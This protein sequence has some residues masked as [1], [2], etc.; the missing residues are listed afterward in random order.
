MVLRRITLLGATAL[1]V[2]V[3]VAHYSNAAEVASAQEMPS[4]SSPCLND[5]TGCRVGSTGPAGGVVFYDAGSP[6]WWGR[7]LEDQLESKPALGGGGEL[8]A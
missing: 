1:M 5:G 2:V 4:T 7:F 6:Q 3:S 8:Y